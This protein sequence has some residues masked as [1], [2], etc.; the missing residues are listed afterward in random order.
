MIDDINT[1]SGEIESSLKGAPIGRSRLYEQ[2]AARIESLIVRGKLAPGDHLPSE[3]ELMALFSVGRPAVREALFDLQRKGIL[4]AKAGSR[5]VVASPTSEVIFATLSGT[6]GLYLSDDD[7][8]LDFQK[9]RRVLEVAVV[10][11]VALSATREE[12]ARLEEALKRN[13][14]ARNAP[15]LFIRTDVDFHLA[16]ARMMGSELMVTLYRA[17]HRWLSEQRAVSMSPA[18]SL[19]AA[20]DV[21]QEIFDAI[22]SHDAA[23]AAAAMTRHLADVEKFYWLGKAAHLASSGGPDA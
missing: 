8:M 7:G 18:G 4:L 15:E 6:V 14:A 13:L 5:P 19:Q 10:S 9:A 1:I 3:R 2:I 16:I 11:E 22:R 12:V 20:I 21:H 23:A 17:M